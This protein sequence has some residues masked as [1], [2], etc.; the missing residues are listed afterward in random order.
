MKHLLPPGI[1]PTMITPYREDRAIDFDALHALV[2]WYIENGVNGL[3][4]VCQSSEMFFLDRDEREAL[5]SAVVRAAAGR[6][7]VIASGH[8]SDKLDD[9]IAD[10]ES[11]AST[12]VDAV[13]LLSNRLVKP[14][15]SEAEFLR[16]AEALLK[17]IDPSVQ[18]G[19]YECPYPYPRLLTIPELSWMNDTGRFRFLKDTSCNESVLE[20]R[21]KRFSGSTLALYNAN[22]ATLLPTLRWGYAGFSGVMANFHPRLYRWLFDHQDESSEAVDRVQDFL[23]FASV[24]EH[25]CYPV[26]AKYHLQISGVPIR[27]NGRT[28]NAKQFSEAMAK[29]IDQMKQHTEEIT[30]WYT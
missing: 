27:V 10:I 9:Q 8:V 25:Q 30:R 22:S 12:G 7:P 28:P 13:V 24:V 5:S 23:G 21:A 1:W 16:N 4:A 15:G 17:Q 29:T 19:M 11:I 14:D 20:T 2:D 26:N 6:C 18:L 3:F